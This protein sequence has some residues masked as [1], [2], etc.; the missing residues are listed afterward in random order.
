MDQYQAATGLTSQAFS[1]PTS[2]SQECTL[3]RCTLAP[4]PFYPT[5]RSNTYTQRSSRSCYTFTTPEGVVIKSLPGQIIIDAKSKKKEQRKVLIRSGVRH[6]LRTVLI[7]I[8]NIKHKQRSNSVMFFLTSF[9]SEPF[10]RKRK[11]K[12]VCTSHT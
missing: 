3:A 10:P 9:H 1:F 2:T 12:Q 6:P 7:R 5:L 8:P 11:H 4:T